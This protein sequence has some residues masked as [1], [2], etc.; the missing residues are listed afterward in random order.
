MV[1]V[2]CG[3]YYNLRGVD[4]SKASVIE[5]KRNFSWEGI[6]DLKSKWKLSFLIKP[7][8]GCFAFLKRE[9]IVEAEYFF[10]VIINATDSNLTE[11]KVPLPASTRVSSNEI[12]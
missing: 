7:T 5:C 6:I 1:N 2:T 11:G 8:T 10:E 9:D 4:Q 12:L 3:T